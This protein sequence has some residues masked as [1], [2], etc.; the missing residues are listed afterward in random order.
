MKGV[1]NKW[2]TGSESFIV[3]RIVENEVFFFTVET[4]THHLL[5]NGQLVPETHNQS[6]TDKSSRY[7]SNGKTRR[8]TGS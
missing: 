7:K 5:L 1:L 2:V 3:N 4:L 6:E 8:L